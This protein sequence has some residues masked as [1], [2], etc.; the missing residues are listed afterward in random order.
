[1]IDGDI[2]LIITATLLCDKSDEASQTWSG[3]PA[4]A[5]ISLTSAVTNNPENAAQNISAEAG[6]G[7][8]ALTVINER[9]FDL[10]GTG[11]KGVMIPQTGQLNWPIPV[12]A[13]SGVVLIIVGVA[14][15]RKKRDEK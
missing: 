6:D 4:D 10:P 5:L 12:L 8:T 1:M 2:G 15:L 3:T 9:T 7:A 11:G 14:M 13:F